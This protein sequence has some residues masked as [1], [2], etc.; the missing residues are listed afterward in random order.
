MTHDV[1]YSS[2]SP[3]WYTP[4]LYIDA[5]RAVMGGIDLDPASCETAQQTVQAARYFTQQDNGLAHAWAER[6]WLN[7]P[8][9]DQIGPWVRRLMHDYEAGYISQAVLLA[10]ARPDT[11]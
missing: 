11:A 4:A 2:N 6:V 9:G 10:P 8:Y 1:M 7:P 5:A 3:E